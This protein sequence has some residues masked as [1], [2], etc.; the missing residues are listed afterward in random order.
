MSEV[1][2]KFISTSELCERYG[3]T[4]RTLA[5]WPETRGFPKPAISHNGSENLYLLEDVET[6][7]AGAM[8]KEA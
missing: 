4:S 2:K 5:R 3:K 1:A 8:R 7:E 6:W